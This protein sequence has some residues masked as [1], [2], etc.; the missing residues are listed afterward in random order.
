MVGPVFDNN[1]GSY[2]A[3]IVNSIAEAVMISATVNALAL[4]DT[5]GFT[6]QAGAAD[7]SS[8]GTSVV[9]LP[10]SAV[11]DGSSS[12][13][14]TVTLTDSNGNPATGTVVIGVSGSALLG[15]VQGF[16]GHTYTCLL[17]T[18]PSPRDA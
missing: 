1:D 17:Y 6:T 5:A 14:V 15:A 10:I 18:S 11:A 2:T 3:T 4:G 8:T 7:A 12:M 13:V 16:G 9:I